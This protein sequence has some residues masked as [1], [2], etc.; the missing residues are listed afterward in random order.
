MITNYDA[1]TGITTQ[2]ELSAELAAE[3][4]AELK[5][6]QDANA[7]KKTAR[8]EILAKLNLTPAEAAILLG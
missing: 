8:D 5:A 2:H 1:A 6:I 3:R 7:A 4:A